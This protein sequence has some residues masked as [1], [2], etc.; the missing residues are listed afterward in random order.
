[1]VVPAI[2]L[3]LPQI[4][5]HLQRDWD[6]H[7][8]VECGGDNAAA[9]HATAGT[10]ATAVGGGAAGTASSSPTSRRLEAQQEVVAAQEGFAAE[11]ERFVADVAASFVRLRRSY[12]QAKAA[13]ERLAQLQQQPQQQQQQPPPPQQ[14]SGS[15]GPHDAVAH[16]EIQPARPGRAAL[17]SVSPN[18]RS[19]CPDNA[20]SGEPAG[21]HNRRDSTARYRMP[22]SRWARPW[23]RARHGT[24]GAVHIGD[25]VSEET[26]P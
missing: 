18:S 26:Q 25:C 2:G 24:I 5:A 14:S 19:R 11:K 16:A 22:R 3:R 1:M 23:A 20:G 13:A 15:A 21:T 10:S 4:V 17:R 8:R 7:G 6:A 9:S 12:W